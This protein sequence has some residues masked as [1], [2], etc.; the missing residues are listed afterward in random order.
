[1]SL[2]L[3]FQNEIFFIREKMKTMELE[4]EKEGERDSS[5]AYYGRTESAAPRY[6]NQRTKTMEVP[7]QSILDAMLSVDLGL[8]DRLIQDTCATYVQLAA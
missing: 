1:M 7:Q 4:L 6:I 5:S 2:S 8:F 3:F